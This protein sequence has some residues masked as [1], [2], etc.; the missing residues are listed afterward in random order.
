MGMM[1][2]KRSP[3]PEQD[4]VIDITDR[5]IALEN[6]SHG[7]L[8]AFFALVFVHIQQ[9]ADYPLKVICFHAAQFPR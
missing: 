3:F 6:F 5:S 8:C 9:Y 4:N 7:S 2:N 1:A